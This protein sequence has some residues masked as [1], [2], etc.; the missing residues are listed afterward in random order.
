MANWIQR[1]LNAIATHKAN[2]AAHHAKYTDAEAIAAA[3]TDTA[4]KNPSGMIIMWHGTIANIP[5]GWVV[6]DGNN[7]TPNLLTRFI[8]GVATAATNPG[9]TGGATAKTTSGHTHSIPVRDIKAVGSSASKLGHYTYAGYYSIAYDGMSCDRDFTNNPN[10]HYA[11]AESGTS[12]SKTAS[13]SDIRPKYY[14][15]AFLMKT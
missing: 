6:C 11:G 2:A 15:V 1:F 10:S 7:S 8:E 4:L 12:G 5:S 9:A 3:K 13:I 14:D